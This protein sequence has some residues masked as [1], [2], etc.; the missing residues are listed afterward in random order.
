MPHGSPGM[1][2]ARNEPYNVL[3]ID[4]QGGTTVFSRHGPVDPRDSMM[5]LK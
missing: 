2:G 3:L 5:R 4:K 1:E